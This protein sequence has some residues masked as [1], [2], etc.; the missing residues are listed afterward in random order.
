MSVKNS[1]CTFSFEAA[2]AHAQHCRLCPNPWDIH[3]PTPAA[4]SWNPSLDNRARPSASELQ[5]VSR[6]RQAAAPVPEALALNARASTLLE[7]TVRPPEIIAIIILVIMI[8]IIIIIAT[9]VTLTCIIMN[10]AYIYIYIYTCVCICGEE[11]ARFSGCRRRGGL[12][13]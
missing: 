7:A 5:G 13:G 9:I 8:I 1:S 11:P 10:H 12:S 4:S 3:W 6:S 2:K